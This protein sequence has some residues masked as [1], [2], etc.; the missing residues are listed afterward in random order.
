MLASNWK[1]GEFQACD[2]VKGLF[3]N[4][5]APILHV[6]MLLAT[7]LLSLRRNM[8]PA[9]ANREPNYCPPALGG[10]MVR[11]GQGNPYF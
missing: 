2:E 1:K 7:N 11:I 6:R 10:G 3:L 8:V 4:H 5:S 9:H